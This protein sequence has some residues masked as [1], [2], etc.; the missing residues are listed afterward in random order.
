MFFLNIFIYF[1]IIIIIIIA[2][3]VVNGNGGVKA[4]F[5]TNQW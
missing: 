2:S 5:D 4:L 1:I 3:N